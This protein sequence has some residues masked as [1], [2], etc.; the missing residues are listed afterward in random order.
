MSFPRVLSEFTIRPFNLYRQAEQHEA[1]L[2]EGVIYKH[3]VSFELR[4]H[5]ECVQLAI[6]LAT[7]RRVVLTTGMRHNRVW[8]ELM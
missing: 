4:Q 6:Q 7:E 2:H 3:D 1:I 8:V 5:H